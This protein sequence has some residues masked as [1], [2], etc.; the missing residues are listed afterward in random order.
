MSSRSMPMCKVGLPPSWSLNLDGAVSRAVSG[1]HFQGSELEFCC[2]LLPLF[3][4]KM[5]RKILN[6]KAFEN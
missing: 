3:A 1:E 5:G 4:K 6:S 2:H